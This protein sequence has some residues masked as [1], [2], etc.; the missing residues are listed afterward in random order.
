MGILLL[1]TSPLRAW[2][3]YM[4][5]LHTTYVISG[6]YQQDYIGCTH[7][8]YA[9]LL[10]S[11]LSHATNNCVH[12]PFQTGSQT[13]TQRLD[14]LA[15]VGWHSIAINPFSYYLTLPYL[16]TSY[17]YHISPSGYHY[18]LLF[19]PRSLA[20]TRNHLEPTAFQEGNLCDP[21]ILVLPNHTFTH[22]VAGW[23]LARCFCMW[24]STGRRK[25]MC[26]GVVQRTGHTD[27]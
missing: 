6:L 16:M 12:Y 7:F 27:Q 10:N 15:W 9:G 2:P 19:S 25:M 17:E 11:C 21:F 23:L 26:R 22:M 14:R 5:F 8:H 1:R 3:L 18:D 4:F 13:R 20:D 24:W